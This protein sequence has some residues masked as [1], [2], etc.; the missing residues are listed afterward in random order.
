MS[1]RYED[2]P[3]PGCGEPLAAGEDIVTC[4]DCGAPQHRACWKH[5]EHCALSERHGKDFVWLPPETEE[6]AKVS[7]ESEE[8]LQS[9]INRWEEQA[10]SEPDPDSP[11]FFCPNC[12]R[13]NKRG[14]LQCE[15]C[16]YLFFAPNPKYPAVPGTQH[17]WIAGQNDPM[18]VSPEQDLGGANAGD[19]VLFI[20]RNARIYLH[21]F[22]RITEGFRRLFFNWAAF[23]FRGYWFLYRKMYGVAGL[24]F[25]ASIGLFAF[26]AWQFYNHYDAQEILKLLPDRLEYIREEMSAFRLG[27][28]FWQTVANVIKPYLPLIFGELALGTVAGFIADRVYYKKATQT[29]GTLRGAN[30]DEAD[31]QFATL[32]EGGVVLFRSGAALVL[33]TVLRELIELVF[34]R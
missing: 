13:K 22:K 5:G 4:P 15:S 17:V 12:G 24:F 11:H 31:F 25:L 28:T 1:Q 26:T 21:R 19:L 7:A 20:Q 32:R 29:V 6:K 3:C 9:H 2:L 16:G 33:M 8:R 30:N 27:S 23:I 18:Y 10:E 34:A 14:N